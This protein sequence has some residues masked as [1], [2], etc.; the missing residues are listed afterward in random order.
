[1]KSFYEKRR[2]SEKK[3]SLIKGPSF[4]YPPHFHLKAEIFA[5]KKGKYQITRNGVTYPV[6]AGDTVFFDSYDIHS[7]DKSEGETEGVVLIIPPNT[8]QKFFTRKGGKKVIS[9]VISDRYLCEKIYNL[10]YEY[11]APENFKDTVKSGA[12]ELILGLIEERLNLGEFL[13]DETTLA[14]NILTYI[15]ENYKGDLSLKTLSKSFGYTP[16]HI[17]RVFHRYLNSGLPEYVNGLRLDYVEKALKE[18]NKIK[19]TTLLFDAGFKSIQSY[20]RA[21]NKAVTQK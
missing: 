7:Y 10:A 20:Y 18:N 1:M 11:V 3:I 15:H 17:S 12:V 6:N 14:Q 2:D 9:P 19:I 4:L 5:L 16:E 8:A 21:K 13:S